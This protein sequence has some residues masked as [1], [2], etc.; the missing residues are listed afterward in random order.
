M[1]LA[2]D[3]RNSPNP[4]AVSLAYSDD[5]VWRNR[6]EFVH[7]RAEVASFLKRK[8][9]R[10]IDY[11]VIKELWAFQ[12]ERIAVRYAYERHDDSGNWFR[13]YGNENW[14]F[15]EDGLI[16]RRFSPP[17]MTC[18]SPQASG[19]STGRLAGG[20]M[21]I[22]RSSSSAYRPATNQYA[23]RKATGLAT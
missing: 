9:S 12:G 13:S 11:R 15:R 20:R 23:T 10:E 6:S 18:R 1:R 22:C 16:R 7:G 17:S 19:N 5:T 3:V 21:A 14:E 8:W 4:E 2:E